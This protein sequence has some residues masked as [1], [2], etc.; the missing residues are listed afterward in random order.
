MAVAIFLNK[1]NKFLRLRRGR[2]VASWYQVTDVW[3]THGDMF[4]SVVKFVSFLHWWVWARRTG[5]QSFQPWRRISGWD[6]MPTDLNRTAWWPAPESQVFVQFW[7]QIVI[8][9]KTS[10][11]SSVLRA[12]S[13]CLPKTL[14]VQ[15]SRRK[16][17]LTRHGLTPAHS[18]CSSLI[19]TDLAGGTHTLWCQQGQT[20]TY[21]ELLLHFSTCFALVFGGIKR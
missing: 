3:T 12:T 13:L 7:S 15:E 17:P 14:S 10:S 18:Q 5:V 21:E 20:C 6:L 9:S 1:N 16:A 4:G 8:I 2:P 19:V 11:N